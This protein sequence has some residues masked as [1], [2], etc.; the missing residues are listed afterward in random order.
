MNADGTARTRLTTSAALDYDAAW[1]PQP[2]ADLALSL[3][4]T[5]DVAR[6]GKPLTYT[7]TV[8]NAGPSNAHEVV[9]TDAL[10]A[11]ARFV[12]AQTSSGSCVT[13]APGAIGTITCTLGFLP[14]TQDATAQIVVKVVVKK[15]TI[16]N[17]ANVTSATPDPNPANDAATIATQVR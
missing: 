10:P 2:A 11:G 15:T 9:V 4:A 17:P 14:A 1:Q 12:S 13:P 7:I 6:S 3:A 16:T 8:H 5:P